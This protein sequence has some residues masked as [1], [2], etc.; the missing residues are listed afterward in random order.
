[1]KIRKIIRR[2]RWTKAS[3]FFHIFSRIEE[4]CHLYRKFVSAIRHPIYAL[5]K[6]TDDSEG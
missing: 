5:K 3:S 6:G 2:Y 1:M 4:I